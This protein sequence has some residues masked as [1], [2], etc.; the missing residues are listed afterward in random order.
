MK[1]HLI[2]ISLAV[3]IITTPRAH[4]LFGH[5]AD[6][7]DRR[8]HAE[9]QLTQQERSNAHLHIAISILS[10]GVTVALIVG[11]AVGVADGD[12]CVPVAAVQP[13]RNDRK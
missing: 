1:L 4:A 8:E 2:L 11:S 9:Q 5:V 3:L 7:R 13:G 12:R 10:A 6:E